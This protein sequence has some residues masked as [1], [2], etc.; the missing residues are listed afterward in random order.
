[1]VDRAKAISARCL[2][3]R[4]RPTAAMDSEPSQRFPSLCPPVK[5][6]FVKFEA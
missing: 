2:S 3:T 4:K 5:S 6:I 1:M